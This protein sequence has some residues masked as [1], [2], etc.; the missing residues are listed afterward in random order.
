MLQTVTLKLTQAESDLMEKLLQLKKRGQSGW[1]SEKYES[2]SDIL[3]QGLMAL[4]RLHKLL[5]EETKET[6][7][8]QRS[9]RGHAPRRGPRHRIINRAT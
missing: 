5:D 7:Q 3:R 4:G 6:L 2:K 8:E 1:R 9:W